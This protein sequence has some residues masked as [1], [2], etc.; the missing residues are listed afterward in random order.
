MDIDIKSA[1]PPPSPPGHCAAEVGRVERPDKSTV[2]RLELELTELR[3]RWMRA[4]AEVANV[5]MRA[6]RD[7]DEARQFAVQKFAVDVVEAAENLHRGVASLPPPSA[8][9]PAV[10]HNMRDGFSGIERSFT[11]LLQ[12]N[13]IERSDPTGTAFDPGLHQAMEERQTAHSPPGTVLEAWSS[14]WTLN[15]RILRPAMVVLATAP[16]D[17]TLRSEQGTQA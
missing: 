7:V 11:A 4:E 1:E 9:E 2:A 8:H 12:R 6:R 14:V 3:D 13:G 17:K 15:G 16:G 5:R 10:I